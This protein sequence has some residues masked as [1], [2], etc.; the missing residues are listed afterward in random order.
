M[1]SITTDG[2]VAFRFYRPNVRQVTIVGDFNEWRRDALP[3]RSIG[4]GWWQ[5]VIQ[6]QGGDYRFRYLADGTWFTDYASNGIESGRLGLNS[7]LT[8]PDLGTEQSNAK[9]RQVA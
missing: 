2:T 8:V 6:L 4:D 5:A 3:M 9:V 7:L 1:T